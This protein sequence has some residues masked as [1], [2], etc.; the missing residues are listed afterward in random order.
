MDRCR[1]A[2]SSNRRLL[3]CHSATSST[4]HVT[5]L[6]ESSRFFCVGFSAKCHTL[7]I[8][9]CSTET[10]MHGDWLEE[11]SCCS[12]FNQRNPSTPCFH[13]IESMNFCPN[14][15]HRFSLMS[16]HRFAHSE[17]TISTFSTVWKIQNK[18]TVP[19]VACRFKVFSHPGIFHSSTNT[20]CF[21]YFLLLHFIEVLNLKILSR[22]SWQAN[23]RQYSCQILI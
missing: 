5:K 12:S 20:C 15:I 22:P 21:E 11:P 14:A 1:Y 19:L 4:T 8:K 3:P 2:R 7:V 18:L 16:S 6:I 13:S 17:I 23:S 9:L 10:N